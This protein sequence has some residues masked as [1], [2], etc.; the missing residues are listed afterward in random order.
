MDL[1]RTCQ[2][3]PRWKPRHTGLPIDQTKRVDPTRL[4]TTL[5]FFAEVCQQMNGKT[6][7]VDDNMLNYTPVQP[8]GV[9]AL[10]SPWERT[11]YDRHMEG[12]AASGAG[13][14]RG[15]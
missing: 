2:R 11:V 13:Q 7:P 3:S 5:N 10:V 9:C 12:R 15:T 1:T 8:V 4:P 6:Y 14:Y